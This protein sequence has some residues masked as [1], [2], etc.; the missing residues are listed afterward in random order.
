[1]C[2]S[3]RHIL[4]THIQMGK[5]LIVNDIELDRMAGNN[6]HH[7]QLSIDRMQFNNKRFF[8]VLNKKFFRFFR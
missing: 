1:M 4:Q 7:L 5:L 6:V 3:R 8:F 2:D